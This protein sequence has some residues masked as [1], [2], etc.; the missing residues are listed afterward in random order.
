MFQDYGRELVRLTKRLEA[1]KECPLKIAMIHYPP[2]PE[3][4]LVLKQHDVQTVLYGHLHL[5]GNELPLP[6]EWHGLRALCVAADRLGFAP[7]LV[8]TH[9]FI[10]TDAGGS[11]SVR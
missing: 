2:L 11:R 1:I 6:E 3:F 8:A 5:N 4:A 7:R 10:R 9:P